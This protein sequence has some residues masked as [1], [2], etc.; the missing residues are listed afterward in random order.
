MVTTKK[1][2]H[3]AGFIIVIFFLMIIAHTISVGWKDIL[4]LRLNPVMLLKDL[5]FSFLRVTVVALLM[6]V[7]S[8]V[9]A[10]FLYVFIKVRLLLNPLIQFIRHISPF[11]WL[12]FAIIWF[13]IGELPVAFVMAVTLFFPML[14][15]ILAVFENIPRKFIYEAMVC[16]ASKIQIAFKVEFPLGLK[17]ILNVFR[18]TWGLGW[19][20]IIAAEML[21]VYSGLGFRMLDFR[22]LLD[23]GNMM[24]YFIIM[25]LLG[26]IFDYFMRWII[27]LLNPA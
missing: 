13:G 8:T 4:F 18:V 5:I 10:Y 6:I 20:M 12:P 9:F 23:Y 3:I 27:K 1:I 21:G 25:G 2:I 22:Y 16:G 26:I 19:A 24:V 7:C 14:V 15:N 11:A 17:G